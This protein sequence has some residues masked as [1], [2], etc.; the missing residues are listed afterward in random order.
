MGLLV[1]GAP[2]PL[3]SGTARPRAHKHPD[4]AA[5]FRVHMDIYMG[6]WRNIG[7]LYGFKWVYGDLY[8]VG[9]I[10]TTLKNDG[11]RQLGR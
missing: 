6:L 2:Y 5:A 1:Y 10:P 4:F 7:Y 3:V 8:L 9:G 11:V